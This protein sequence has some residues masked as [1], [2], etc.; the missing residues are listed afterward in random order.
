VCEPCHHVKYSTT[1]SN[2]YIIPGSAPLGK[3]TRSITLQL[4]RKHLMVSVLSGPSICLRQHHNSLNL[5]YHWH[6]IYLV[7]QLRSQPTH[8]VNLLMRPG[9]DFSVAQYPSR[10]LPQCELPKSE[11]PSL[12]EVYGPFYFVSDFSLSIDRSNSCAP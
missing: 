11:S 7:H 4:W 6:V 3:L 8:E 1:L 5:I 9:Q 10:Q 2:S 12:L